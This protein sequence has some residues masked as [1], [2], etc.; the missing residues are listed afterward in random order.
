MQYAKNKTYP[1]S[2]GGTNCHADATAGKNALSPDEGK[3]PPKTSSECA[4]PVKPYDKAAAEKADIRVTKGY[5]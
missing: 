1:G 2:A 3:L 5:L 4:Q